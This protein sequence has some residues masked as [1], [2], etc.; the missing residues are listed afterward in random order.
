MRSQIIRYQKCIRSYPSLTGSNEQSTSLWQHL[1]S[2]GSWRFRC[3]RLHPLVLVCWP[4]WPAFLFLH[5]HL[6][7]TD[8]QWSSHRLTIC[9]SGLNSNSITLGV[10]FNHFPPGFFVSYPCRIQL[11][12]VTTEFSDDHGFRHIVIFGMCSNLALMEIQSTALQLC[13]CSAIL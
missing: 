5:I 11:A 10:S 2:F 13:F 3:H 7:L 1:S 6:H 4:L 9:I 12:L 8:T